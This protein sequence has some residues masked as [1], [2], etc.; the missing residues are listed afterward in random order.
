VLSFRS[1]STLCT[2]CT[3]LC[4]PRPP[5]APA[6]ALRRRSVPAT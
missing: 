1:R 5:R 6:K 4:A 3:T 2:V